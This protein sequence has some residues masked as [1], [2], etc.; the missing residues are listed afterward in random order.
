[1]KRKPLSRARPTHYL[2]LVNRKCE[3][4][5]KLSPSTVPI[6]GVLG[7]RHLRRPPSGKRTYLAFIG[8]C[9]IESGSSCGV[10]LAVAL[11]C[12]E[13]CFLLA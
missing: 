6:T 8:Q 7:T 2:D 9:R 10:C 4:Q 11:V 3:S 1:M 5:M 12:M 13:A